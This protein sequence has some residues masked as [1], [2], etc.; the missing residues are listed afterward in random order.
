MADLEPDGQAMDPKS[1]AVRVTAVGN[2]RVAIAGPTPALVR[3]ARRQA[4]HL[5][6]RQ[7]AGVQ[8]PR[9]LPPRRHRRDAL[10]LRRLLV[11]RAVQFSRE[12][13]GL[14]AVRRLGAGA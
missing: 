11:D 4:R 6:A 7:G 10:A 3:D 8:R 9:L 1:E 14:L 2:E 12:Q 13:V 5:P